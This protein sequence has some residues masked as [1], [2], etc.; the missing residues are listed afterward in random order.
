[1]IRLWFIV[2]LFTIV[3]VI[4]AFV[5]TGNI[6]LASITV[7]ELLE[8]VSQPLSLGVVGYLVKSA[9]ENRQKIKSNP[10]FDD[11]QI[12]QSPGMMSAPEEDTSA[13]DEEDNNGV[14]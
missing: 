4:P 8:Y 12:E 7:G 1:M 6:E 10:F 2:A 13:M 14:Y 9:A 11:S 3:V 5:F